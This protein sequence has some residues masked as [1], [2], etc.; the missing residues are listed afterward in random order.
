MDLETF[1][2]LLTDEGR[3][4]LAA[5]QHADPAD[6]ART[7]AALRREHA[8]ELVTAAVE[9]VRLRRA[10]A[11][12][13]GEF[14]PR[15]YFTP[16]GLALSSHLA[17]AE[18]K[19]LRVV[20]E[21]GVVLIDAM[22]LGGGHDATVLSWSHYTAAVDPD[23][24]TVE[25][26]AANR[27]V[28]DAPMLILRR[29][30]VMTFDSQGEAVFIDLKR[31]PGPLRGGAAEAGHPPL[32]WA[33]DRVRTTGLGWI[34]LA[35]DVRRTLPDLAATGADEA[36]WISYGGEAQEAVLWYLG[37][38][39]D[40]EPPAPTR[41]PVRKVTL[42]PGGASLTGRGLPHPAV[43][44]LGRYLYEPD[45]AVVHAGLLAEV[46]E[47]VHGGPV[48][49]D[50]PLLTADAPHR[51]PFATAHRVTDVLRGEDGAEDRG[52]DL[53]DL[54]RRALPG[55]HGV[56]RIVLASPGLD[57]DPEEF[58]QHLAPGGPDAPT[59]FLTRTNA[60]PA[61]VTAQRVPEATATPAPAG[62]GT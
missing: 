27:E 15:M 5:L 42:L 50:G 32:S 17:V 13:F 57:V 51:T 4:V 37:A 10:A 49:P 38:G 35:P 44:P 11:G 53:R 48:D 62:S 22:C 36:E 12:R 16:E 39:G 3:S 60:G 21:M 30:D 26:A 20:G 1:R 19:L 24:L 8:D 28:L 18:Y 9:Q 29:E 43:R 61:A 14:A 56:A 40:L 25:M 47:E 31:H 6:E 41:V 55:G 45:P 46:A 59:L 23:P 58:A 7:A 52:E 54:L 2:S 34:R 33:S